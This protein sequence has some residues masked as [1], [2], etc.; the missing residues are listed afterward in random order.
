MA[1]KKQIPA[2]ARLIAEQPA[3]LYAIPGGA[4]SGSA[5]VDY[6]DAFLGSPAALQIEAISRGAPAGN[7]LGAAE[8][9]HLPRERVYELVGLSVST[10]KRKVAANEVLDPLV[11]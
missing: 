7:L 6:R 1:G 8:A 11:T 5:W 2:A 3:A 9:L 10:A 4:R